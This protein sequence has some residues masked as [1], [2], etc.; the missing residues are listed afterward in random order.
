MHM[1]SNGVMV[2][3]LTK[4]VHGLLFPRKG[5]SGKPNAKGPV[6]RASVC[7]FPLWVT[8][9]TWQCN[10]ATSPE[11]DSW[12]LSVRSYFQLIAYWWSVTA[13]H[14]GAYSIHEWL[15]V[16]SR[17]LSCNFHLKS[18]RDSD[19]LSVCDENVLRP[20]VQRAHFKVMKIHLFLFW[21]LP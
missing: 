12:S 9:Q 18:P 11:E 8:V 1:P 17:L 19:K 4:R 20:R 10:M 6:C 14:T 21:W 16:T 13:P 5:C 7:F 2:N 15:K 3:V